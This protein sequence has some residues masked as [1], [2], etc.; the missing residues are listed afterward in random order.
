MCYSAILFCSP[1]TYQSRGTAYSGAAPSRSAAASTYGRN[2]YVWA[3][4]DI[5]DAVITSVCVG[6]SFTLSILFTVVDTLTMHQ[7]FTV[8]HDPAPLHCKYREVR[9]VFSINR[10]IEMTELILSTLY[11]ASLLI[12]AQTDRPF[13]DSVYFILT[14][15]EWLNYMKSRVLEE[16]QRYRL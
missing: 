3:P 5:Y 8:G 16:I 4:F 1:V 7:L 10:M 12:A 14:F 11:K 9:T 15:F 6:V 13:I 2:A